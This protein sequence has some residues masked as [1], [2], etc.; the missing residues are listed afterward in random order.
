M[1][2]AQARYWILTIPFDDF[3]PD[4]F[5]LL[6]AKVA[7]IKGQGELGTGESAYKHWQ[8]MVNFKRAVRLA[9]V[10]QVFGRTCHAEPTRSDAA[11]Q[12]VWKDETSIEGTR[13]ERGRKPIDRGESKDWAAI[14][15]AACSGR[16]DDIPADVY[17]R[18]YNA[19]KRIA[20]DH[21]EPVAIERIIH[22]YWGSTGVGKSR[23]A[24]EEAGINAYPKDPRSKFWDGY[25]NQE[26]VVVDEFRGGIDISHVLRW[27]DRYPVIIEIKGSSTV[28]SATKIWVTSN[29]H[30]RFWYPDLDG[31]TFDALKRRMKIY[32]VME[33]GIL[34]S[35]DGEEIVL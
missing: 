14:K 19:L 17:V 5:E 7:Y 34:I 31:V 24:W 6:D 28:L 1:P 32:E 35:E 15:D 18:N 11:S 2:S 27:F 29:L 25:H 21:M 30:P 8:I 16:L 12:Y 10:K 33:G 4:N 3:A 22:V 26:H 23:R 20:V 9:A 13:F